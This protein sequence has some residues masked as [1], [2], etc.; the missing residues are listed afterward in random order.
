MICLF[1]RP[2]MGVVLMELRQPKPHRN[3]NW[4]PIIV[5][6]N[7]KEINQF[8]NIQEVFRFFKTIVNLSNNRIYDIIS[9][10]VFELQP[11]Y[12]DKDIY[13]FRTYEERRQKHFEELELN[14]E[15]GRKSRKRRK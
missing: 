11:W 12:K 13:E 15:T 5:Y 6:K 8:N 14:K 2:E 10:G 9:R 4:V 1:S 3:Q 7:K